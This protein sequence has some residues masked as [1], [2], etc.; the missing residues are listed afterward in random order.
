MK[1]ARQSRGMTQQD[2]ADRLNCAK[3]S[4]SMYE[5]NKREP[6]FE[7]VEAIADILNVNIGQLMDNAIVDSIDFGATI[8]WH[9]PLTTAYKR[10]EPPTRRAACNV[11]EIP[12]VDPGKPSNVV[13][14]KREK[15]KKLIE[16]D[17]YPIG[18]LAGT[19]SDFDTPPDSTALEVPEDDMPYNADFAVAI[20]GHS[21]EPGIA[22]ESIVWVH[23][24]QTIDDNQIGIFMVGTSAVCKRAIV[25][26]VGALERLQSDND[27]YPDIDP[28]DLPDDE[29]IKVI[30]RVVGSYLG[31]V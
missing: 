27:N 14:M 21:M 5:G 10:A 8:P 4:I 1:D 2:L 24:Q 28:D 3:S 20:D 22:N 18:A 31:E 29:V 25:N 16:V 9:H 26:S 13:P 15:S 30:G 17:L 19:P 11:L 6:S 7:T 23:E 12:Y